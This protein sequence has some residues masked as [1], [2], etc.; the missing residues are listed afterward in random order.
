MDL[1][2]TWEIC[3]DQDSL[4]TNLNLG[5]TV[6][7]YAY[8]LDRRSDSCKQITEEWARPLVQ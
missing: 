5:H 8:E 4:S 1:V 2:C 3:W 6:Y 7:M